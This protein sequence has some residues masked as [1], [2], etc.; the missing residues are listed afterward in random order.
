MSVRRS[1]GVVLVLAVMGLGFPSAG[2]AAIGSDLG[3]EEVGLGLLE[4]LSRLLS[5]AEVVL[6]DL[7]AQFVTTEGASITDSG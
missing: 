6:A 4:R 5:W 3:G 2:E 7:G 1:V